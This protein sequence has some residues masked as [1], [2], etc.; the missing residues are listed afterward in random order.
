M[1]NNT[2][3]N[4]KG[5]RIRTAPAIKRRNNAIAVGIC[6]LIPAAMLLIMENKIMPLVVFC[7]ALLIFFKMF[8]PG[9]VMCVL[10]EDRMYYYSSD[11]FSVD[12]VRV[13]GV[14]KRIIS[15]DGWISYR[16]AERFEYTPAGKWLPSTLTIF[17][18]GF[19]LRIRGVD[20]TLIDKIEK[21][22]DEATGYSSAP[23]SE[24]PVV[25]IPREGV[26]RDLWNHLESCDICAELGCRADEI[27]FEMYG[28]ADMDITDVMVERGSKILYITFQA[29]GVT[30]SRKDDDVETALDFEDE[31]GAPI[32]VSE[33][34][35]KIRNYVAENLK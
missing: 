28:D 27:V 9:R 31:G 25:S 15:C 14:R 30:M 33:I 8:I 11:L 29:A 22:R 6:L 4:I 19:E 18:Y 21:K 7:A 13:E 23:Y 10:A 12:F 32:S 35:E 2:Y 26:W 20:R 17:G 16:A 3:K 34:M 5:K 1:E 24:P